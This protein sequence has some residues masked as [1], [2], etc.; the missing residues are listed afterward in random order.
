MWWF[1]SWQKDED[2]MAQEQ[3]AVASFSLRKYKEFAE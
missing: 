3:A 2:V 1:N